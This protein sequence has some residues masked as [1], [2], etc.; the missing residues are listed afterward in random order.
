MVKIGRNRQSLDMLQKAILPVLVLCTIL[1]VLIAAPPH[2]LAEGGKP[3]WTPDGSRPIGFDWIQLTNGEWLKGDLKV[4]YNDS[5]E[6]DSDELDLLT[7]DWED[8]HQVICHEPPG[9]PGFAG[10]AR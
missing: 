3:V 6:F 5:L 2:V 10:P 9:R 4:L 1:S 8:V 7:F